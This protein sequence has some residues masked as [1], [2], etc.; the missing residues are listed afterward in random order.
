MSLAVIELAERYRYK[1]CEAPGCP[2]DIP[3]HHG[4]YCYFHS[5]PTVASGQPLNVRRAD[6]V[7]KH[8]RIEDR[9]LIDHLLLPITL[10]EV[11]M[12]LGAGWTRRMVEGSWL[13]IRSDLGLASGH[14]GNNT[15][16]ER[17][18]LIRIVAGMQAC[19]CGA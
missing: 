11:A 12:R 7:R 15:G 14:P 6:H 4:R 2:T 1:R 3:L 18:T 16:L 17:I 19:F 5:L 10:D 9:L 8:L 13:H